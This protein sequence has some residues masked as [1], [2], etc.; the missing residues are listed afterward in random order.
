VTNAVR[1][2]V[3][4]RDGERCAFVSASGE[5][6]PSIAFLEMDH[7]DARALGGSDDAPNIRVLCRAHNHLAAEK[8]FGR[9]HMARRVREHV[10]PDTCV[11]PSVSATHGALVTLGFRAADARRALATLAE[12]HSPE[13]LAER[14]IE[15]LLREALAVLT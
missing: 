10:S 1:R 9:S 13:M 4:A 8:T 11:A 2:E 3:I 12:R 5:R 7:R 14:S 6:C 15:S